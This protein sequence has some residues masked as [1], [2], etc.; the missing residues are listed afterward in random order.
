M[1]SFFLF[2]ELSGL[3]QFLAV[4]DPAVSEFIRDCKRIISNVRKSEMIIQGSFIIFQIESEL[5]ISK[6]VIEAGTKVLE[7][8]NQHVEDLHEFS[9]MI[10]YRDSK[11]MDSFISEVR[12]EYYTYCTDSAFLVDDEIYTASG[13][14]ES[15]EIQSGFR[16]LYADE[17]QPS[18]AGVIY[19]ELAAQQ[20]VVRLIEL[21]VPEFDEKRIERRIIL[22]ANSDF[23]LK[24]N[25]AAALKKI[26]SGS[27]SEPVVINNLCGE[28][29]IV[30]PFYRS[31]DVD[32]VQK[33]DQYLSGIE[34]K[35]WENR[36]KS[37]GNINSDYPGESFFI[38]YC[39]YLKARIKAFE[40]N[41]IP[42]IIVFKGIETASTEILDYFLRV[43]DF[44]MIET[45][46]FVIF[47]ENKSY[48]LKKEIRE[49]ELLLD[50]AEYECCR[51]IH[52]NGKKINLKYILKRLLFTVHLTEGLFDNSLMEQFLIGFGYDK[53]EISSGFN[54]L[55]AAGCLE[56]GR[57]TYLLKS[58]LSR[59]IIQEIGNRD[60]I[61]ISV[62]S[63]LNENLYKLHNLDFGLAAERLSP[64]IAHDEVNLA[65]YGCLTRLLDHSG[66]KS[67]QR[68]IAGCPDM[69]EELLKALT[70]RC[71]LIEGQREACIEIL[72]NI[73]EK[74]ESPENWK[75]TAL[76]LE[77]GRYFHAM[78]EYPR[79]LDYVKKVLIYLQDEDSPRLEGTAFVEL[80][81]IMMCKGKL[82]ESSEYMILAVE[83]LI[84]SG[85]SYNLMKAYLYSAVGLYL[86]GSFDD[87]L[88]FTEKA[89]QIA[90]DDKFENWHFFTEFFKCRLFFEL[91]RY[92]D[93]EKL[94]SGCL[95]RNEIYRDEKRRKLFLAWTAR[96]CVYQGKVYRG[97]N[98]LKS[99]EEDPEV[100]MFLAEAFFFHGDLE[101]AVEYIDRAGGMSDY[102]TPEFIPLENINW[103]NGFVSVEDRALRSAK[104]TG[105]MLHIIRALHAYFL[106][107]TGD[108]EYGIELLSALT[109][110]QKISENDPYNRLYFYFF[111]ILYDKSSNSDVVDKLTL[112]SKALKY[113]Q[114][115]LLQL[116]GRL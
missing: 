82:L 105:V 11:D 31:I 49:H 107:L 4:K 47:F 65:V 22:R 85:D 62:A 28:T 38:T 16:V 94:L 55:E 35:S 12:Q 30:M 73:T 43:L 96:A 1:K 80:G 91:G 63:F 68:C 111:C 9:L 116:T 100:L 45:E 90:S 42:A 92:Y 50:V 84:N 112:I 69:P 67:V 15:V 10:A 86:W 29:E 54:Q 59:E 64:M 97:L 101:N 88:E 18:G 13:F 56:Q 75:T 37:L 77:V 46:P 102:F 40:V 51:K 113:L 76:Y 19:D 98:M 14:P 17:P 52:L 114:P 104:G 25:I 48:R 53:H 57:Y 27:Y 93:A 70:L 26:N 8:L 79:A 83:K 58:H 34:L 106:G 23:I 78:N 20:E 71:A 74:P 7:N 60:D 81:F 89:V 24:C 32:F 2:I 5:N 33:A 110:D 39:L 99:L 3:Q 103:E 72:K 109:R 61:Y 41:Q 95:L 44:I 36:V 115:I 66:T 6:A 87:S 108:K 21:L